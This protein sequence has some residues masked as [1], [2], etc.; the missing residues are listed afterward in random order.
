MNDKPQHSKFENIGNTQ[1]PAQFAHCAAHT[2]VEP[3]SVR[4]KC[5]VSLPLPRP[6]S[7][8]HCKCTA[9]ILQFGS[10]GAIAERRHCKGWARQARVA[11]EHCKNTV[12][13]GTAGHWQCRGGA[14]QGYS[15][16][17]RCRNTLFSACCFVA[18]VLGG[19][20]LQGYLASGQ[21]RDTLPWAPQGYCGVG[22]CRDILL[23]SGCCSRLLC[24][25]ALQGYSAV[26]HCR[27]SWWLG[28]AGIR[29][30]KHCR[31]CALQGYSAVGRCRN[32]LFSACC[33]VAG[34]PGGSALQGYLASG[35]R[36][37]TLPWAPQGYCGVGNLQGYS[38]TFRLLFKATLRL[39]TAGILCGRALQRF[40]VVGHCR[41]T[42]P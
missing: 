25:W 27:D 19:S 13:L 1:L 32:T 18:G 11:M 3:R 42:L 2:A 4:K 33:F 31:G 24:G 16:V 26:A 9:G 28:T 34:V 23:P 15:A 38:A 7:L 6:F 30:H 20:A 37:D 22:T 10:A 21:R 39:G 35:Q 40:L 29:C 14:L 36:R 41:D 12:G 5:N 8:Q 17:G